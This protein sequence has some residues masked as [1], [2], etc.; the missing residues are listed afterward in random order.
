MQLISLLSDVAIS[1]D[2]PTHLNSLKID[3]QSANERNNSFEDRPYRA[4]AN[5]SRLNLDVSDIETLDIGLPSTLTEAGMHG[6]KPFIL[7]K[8]KRLRHLHWRSEDFTLPGMTG[9]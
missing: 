4:E 3:I 2:G 1:T 8:L 5:F 7:G 9:S 6:W